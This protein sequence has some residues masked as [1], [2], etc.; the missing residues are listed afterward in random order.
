MDTSDKYIKMC[1]SATEIQKNIPIE[2]V[3]AE[4]Y[5]YWET[6]DE[7]TQKRR[8]SYHIYTVIYGVKYYWPRGGN[9]SGGISQA[10][11]YTTGGT[12]SVSD[13]DPRSQSVKDMIWLPKQDELEKL[14]LE[15]KYTD[16]NNDYMPWWLLKDF[17]NF[18]F[19]PTR[20]V[21]EFKSM[22]Q[23]WLVYLMDE[24]YNKEWNS[25]EMKWKLI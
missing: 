6:V 23:L 1:E 4:K 13:N 10:W 7:D 18:V 5:G 22:E 14:M 2:G 15:R 3:F 16:S 8:I 12:L 17:H 21:T 19:N 24:K 9:N 20:I 11:A 25:V